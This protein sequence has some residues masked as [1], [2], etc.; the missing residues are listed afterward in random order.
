[1]M[2]KLSSKDDLLFPRILQLLTEID[3]GLKERVEIVE[4]LKD[5]DAVIATGSDNTNRY[6]ENAAQ[7]A[8]N[9]KKVKPQ[10]HCHTYRARK[11][12]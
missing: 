8:Q 1:M 3:P 7:T 12:R 5:F 6:F 9:I 10:L 11:R 2:I 4:K